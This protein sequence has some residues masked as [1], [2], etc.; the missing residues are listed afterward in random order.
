MSK[1]KVSAVG[2]L[3]GHKLRQLREAGYCTVPISTVRE[4]LETGN[5][6]LNGEAEVSELDDLL[7]NLHREATP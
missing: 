1:K 6:V 4:L 5:D 2:I 3:G 7:A